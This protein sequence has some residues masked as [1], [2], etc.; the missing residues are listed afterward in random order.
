MAYTGETQVGQVLQEVALRKFKVANP[1]G[2]ST[3]EPG[4]CEGWSDEAIQACYGKK[5]VLPKQVVEAQKFANTTLYYQHLGKIVGEKAGTGARMR[6]AHFVALLA[7]E[8][9]L[10]QFP[11]TI[12]VGLIGASL[13][14][15]HVFLILNQG[16][17]A[18]ERYLD[19]WSALQATG[20]DPVCVPGSYKSLL[21]A[22]MGDTYDKHPPRAVLQL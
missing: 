2:T 17:A 14:T 20:A 10:K 13:G 3:Y 1:A 15:G 16:Q 9:K 11:G 7:Y 21:P 22:N 12:H 4:P 19:L 18:D 5:P 6:C 8:L